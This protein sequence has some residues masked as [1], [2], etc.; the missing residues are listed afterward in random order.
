MMNHKFTVSLLATDSVLLSRSCK[1]VSHQKLKEIQVVSKD[2]FWLQNV[3]PY[4]ALLLTDVSNITDSNVWLTFHISSPHYI[5]LSSH[6]GANRLSHSIHLFYFSEA[7]RASVHFGYVVGF[8][9]VKR[10]LIVHFSI[11]FMTNTGDTQAQSTIFCCEGFTPDRTAQLQPFK[12]TLFMY[13]WSF[14][15]FGFWVLLERL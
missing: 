11:L 5:F 9:F 1:Q 10:D 4:E 12:T 15:I 6:S 3:F 13:S 14:H 8:N 2:V 7:L